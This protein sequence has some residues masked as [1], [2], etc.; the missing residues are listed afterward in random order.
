MTRAEAEAL[1]LDFDRSMAVGHAVRKGE[2]LPRV[3]TPLHAEP[4]DLRTLDLIMP[5][6]RP[7]AWKEKDEQRE[8]WRLLKAC[9]Y[10]ICWLSQPARSWQTLGVPDLLARKAG[11]P[12]LWVE[13][14]KW[15]DPAPWTPAQQQFAADVTEHERYVLGT[16]NNLRGYLREEGFDV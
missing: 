5:V 1:G 15:P 16:V 11:K 4:A 10:R 6:D 14:K 9:G 7:A 2:P 12:V 8:C 3:D 13:V